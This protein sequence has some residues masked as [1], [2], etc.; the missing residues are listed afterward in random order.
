MLR[1]GNFINFYPDYSALQKFL[2]RWS[3]VAEI[4]S[5]FETRDAGMDSPDEVL[6]HRGHAFHEGLSNALP[7]GW[8]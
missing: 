6:E 4:F 3:G 1:C 2:T 8:A 7:H 5:T